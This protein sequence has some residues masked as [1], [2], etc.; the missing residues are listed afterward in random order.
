MLEAWL[1][2]VRPSPERKRNPLLVRVFFGDRM[3][4]ERL[5]GLLDAYEQAARERRDRYAEV[6][7][8]LAER[9]R[10]AFRRATAVFG[11]AQ[12]QASLDWIEEV[13]PLL[14]EARASDE[15]RC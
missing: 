14:H 9:P 11:V 12:P 1:D 6:V 15:G 3:S 13:R 8:R 4:S 7:D 10:S 2:D 5:G